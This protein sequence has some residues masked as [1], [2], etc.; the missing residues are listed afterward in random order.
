VQVGNSPLKNVF[1]AQIGAPRVDGVNIIG[2][3]FNGEVLQVDRSR[4]DGIYSVLFARKPE[5]VRVYTTDSR[6]QKSEKSI[7]AV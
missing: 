7:A 3:V 1:Q 2:N 5:L 6:E 4:H